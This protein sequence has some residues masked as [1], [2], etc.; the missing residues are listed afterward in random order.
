MREE[1]KVGLRGLVMVG[2]ALLAVGVAPSSV[3]AQE[4]RCTEEEYRQFDF[5]L[6]EWQVTG[7]DG[8]VAGTNRITS[9]LG[10]CVLME[11]WSSAGSA[12]TGKSFNI[13]DGGRGRW[14]QTWVDTVGRLLELYG[15]LEEGKMV[16]RGERPGRNGSPVMHEISWAPLD[17]GDVRQIW[18][19]SGDGG[20]S[21]EVQFNGLYE[22]LQ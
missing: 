22:R 4:A 1:R 9:I 6:G 3:A 11:E 18:R 20:E 7:A 14:H 19:T 10:G 5:W 16:L 17:G 2:L 12:F 21:W 8:D 15:G 13:Y